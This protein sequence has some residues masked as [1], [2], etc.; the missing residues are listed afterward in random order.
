MT[1]TKLCSEL[2]KR[3]KTKSQAR[4]QAIRSLIGH[5]SDIIHEGE[6]S[7]AGYLLMRFLENGRKRAKK[8]KK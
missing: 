4:I 5:L 8:K 2:A 6:G 3:E 7:Y 1:I